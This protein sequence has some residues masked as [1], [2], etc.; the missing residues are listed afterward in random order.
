MTTPEQLQEACEELSHA[1]PDQVQVI[2][3]PD[4]G[5]QIQIFA[6]KSTAPAEGRKQRKWA[7]VAEKLAREDLLG[8]GRGDRLR[9][10]MREFRENV[11]MRDVFLDAQDK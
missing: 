8:E 3:L 6:V 2:K 1:T 10:A 4:G 7:R 9:A 11:Q 5:M